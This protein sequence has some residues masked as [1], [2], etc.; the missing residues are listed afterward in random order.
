[1]SKNR[2]C[3]DT[4]YEC[5][6]ECNPC[7]CC[8]GSGSE[9]SQG[10]QGERGPEGPQG[11]QGP[12]GQQGERGLDGETGP[13]LQ[14]FVNSNIK[15]KQIVKDGGAVT[16]PLKNETPNEYFA[17]GIDYNGVD[18]FTI[19]YAGLYSLTCVLS[20]DTDKSDNTFYIEL[21]KS[22]PVAS[23]ANMG[24]KG[25]LVLTRVGYLAA[26]TTVR[27]VNGSGF[28]VTLS[29]ASSLLNSTGHLALFR[30]ADNM[31]Q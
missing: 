29:N 28:P 6:C 8:C 21:N 27:I 12:Q 3:D 10:P 16:F 5:M 20:L 24:N 9:G 4:N 13:V 23:T 19:K 15:G 17:S 22:I 18:T 11:P 25:Q 2:P 1:M 7:D 31:M 26:G 30:F 14:P